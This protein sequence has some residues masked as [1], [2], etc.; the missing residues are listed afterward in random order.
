MIWTDLN[1]DSPNCTLH[2]LFDI[3][4]ALFHFQWILI[5]LRWSIAFRLVFIVA[6]AVIVVRN[7]IGFKH[8]TDA[9]HSNLWI[10]IQLM[11]LIDKWWWSL[12]YY[13]QR[14]IVL[15]GTWYWCWYW[16]GCSRRTGRWTGRIQR[17]RWSRRYNDTVHGMRWMGRMGWY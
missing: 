6:I 14:Y 10:D 16:C 15:M 7:Q 1:L 2:Q 11:V 13:W 3:I 12:L 4:H 5:V 9:L 8:L 17:I